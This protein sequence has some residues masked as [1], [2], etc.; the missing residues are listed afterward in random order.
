MTDT[1]R[2]I[3]PFKSM[4]I[5]NTKGLPKRDIIIKQLNNKINLYDNYLNDFGAKNL[6]EIGT[7]KIIDIIK[8]RYFKKKDNNSLSKK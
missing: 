3:I 7:Q 6:D 4:N 8:L 1:I 5:S 2:D